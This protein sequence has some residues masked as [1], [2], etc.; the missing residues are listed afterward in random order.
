MI[1]PAFSSCLS[2]TFWDSFQ[3]NATPNS[4]LLLPIDKDND[5]LHPK[6]KYERKTTSNW[7]KEKK[8]TKIIVN[9][10]TFVI[11][12]DYLIGSSLKKKKKQSISLIIFWSFSKQLHQSS[13]PTHNILK[14]FKDDMNIKQW[15]I[16][17]A[18]VCLVTYHLNLSAVNMLLK[19]HIT[20]LFFFS[21][22]H[23]SSKSCSSNSSLLVCI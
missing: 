21:Q 9:R 10:D 7:E 11:K 22:N 20:Y 6:T 14:N 18:I 4:W 16:L 1:K 23:L 5:I 15:K 13:N 2:M 12:P 8:T 17:L 3:S 19:N